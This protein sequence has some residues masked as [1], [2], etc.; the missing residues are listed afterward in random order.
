MKIEDAD[1]LQGDYRPDGLEAGT[2]VG[3]LVLAVLNKSTRQNILKTNLMM[4]WLV[5]FNILFTM[6]EF[7]RR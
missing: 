7:I 2:V 4:Y 1:L 5:L 6:I 3:L